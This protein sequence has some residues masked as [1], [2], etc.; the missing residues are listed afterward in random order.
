MIQILQSLEPFKFLTNT[1]ILTELDDVNEVLFI[2][3]GLY[4]IGYEVNKKIQ[5]RLRHPEKTLI[6]AFEACFDRRCLFIYK[7]FT[8]CKGYSIRK[9]HWKAL[10][11]DHK[12]LYNA[13]KKKSLFYYVQKIRR[14]LLEQK[15]LDIEHF[16]RR[17][18]YKQVLCLR[19][20]DENEIQTLVNAELARNIYQKEPQEILI[21][22][23]MD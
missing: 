16:G 23:D 2:E 18:D 8:E 5:Y 9:K 12:E 4:D 21:M 7:T 6:G 13:L 1:I 20:Y 14:P 19:N 3:E 17:A 10:E 15:H 11:V 22:K